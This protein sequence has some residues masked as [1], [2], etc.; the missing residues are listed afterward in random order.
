M[1]PES[2]FSVPTAT[3]VQSAHRRLSSIVEVDENAARK[4]IVVEDG[5]IISP[6]DEKSHLEDAI[7]GVAVREDKGKKGQ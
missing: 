6:I 7:K 1:A 5:V 4:G 3:R 2:P